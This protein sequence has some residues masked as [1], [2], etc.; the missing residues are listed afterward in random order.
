MNTT[1]SLSSSLEDY[2][3]VIF[4]LVAQKQVARVKDIA[5]LIH[6]KN[7][8]VTGALRSLAEKGLIH[9]APYDVVTL[10]DKGRDAATDVVRRHEVLRNF[11]INVL[12]VE[13]TE[14]D[15]AA[16]KM[17]HCISPAILERF[18]EFSDYIE[19]CPRSGAQWT[20]GF[21]F[22]CRR[23]VGADSCE[24]CIS[25]LLEQT[26][27]ALPPSD[28]QTNMTTPLNM[29]APG[30]K[31]RIVRIR[32]KGEMNK[33]ILE[34]GVIPGSLIQ[35]ERVAPLGDPI[36]FKIKGYHL[37]LRKDEAQEI[38]VAPILLAEP[39]AKL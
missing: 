24:K 33:R 19:L 2:L 21:G 9:Y 32:A 13:P 38:E 12:S 14:A 28:R 36:Q 34:M 30:Q 3:E 10:T 11:F 1:A 37:T 20:R 5:K 18:V 39:A 25:N 16:C 31:G 35:M 17:E 22:R 29:L 6:V 4:H 8:S 26:K 15:E 27:Q 7:S 23:E